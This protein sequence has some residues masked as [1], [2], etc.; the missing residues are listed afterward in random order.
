[1]QFFFIEIPVSIDAKIIYDQ[2]WT[3]FFRNS[4]Q[5]FQFCSRIGSHCKSRVVF[6]STVFKEERQQQKK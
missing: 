2:N 4:V 6:Y 5:N 1:M 3:H